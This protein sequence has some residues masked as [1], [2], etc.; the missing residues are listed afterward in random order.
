M[1][2]TGLLIFT[3]APWKNRRFA[4]HIRGSLMKNS[5]RVNV[6]AQNELIRTTPAMNMVTAERLLLEAKEILDGLGVQFFLRQGTCLGVVRD[7]AFIPWD[8]DLDLGVILGS[9]G[10]TEESIEP[11]MVEFRKNDYYVAQPESSNN[12]IYS[13]LLKD[14]IRIDLVF[15]RVIA[16]QVYHWPGVW[17]PVKLFHRLKEI[18]FLGNFFLVP[19][20]PEEYLQ[21]KYGPNWRIPKRLD[22]AKD[23]VD[24]VPAE[25]LPGFLKKTKGAL[26]RFLNPGNTAKLR[27]LDANGLPVHKA[28]IRIVGFGNFKTDKQG[29]AKLYLK[30]DRYSPGE[31]SMGLSD[32]GAMYSLVIN[33]GNHEEVLYE[34]LLAPTKSYIYSPDPSQTEGRIFVL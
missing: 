24:N 9:N 30:G 6:E 16:E 20:P 28:N 32:T 19:N 25:S 3:K 13:S 21:V 14:D 7:N 34:E 18:T 33:Y 11:V 1:L 5:D 27:V 15:H 17:F 2:F 23:V 22:Y 29:Y 31:P 4:E 8:D 10:F 26:I 12:V